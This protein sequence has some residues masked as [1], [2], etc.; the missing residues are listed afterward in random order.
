VEV[1]WSEEV[2]VAGYEEGRC[3]RGRDR[4]TRALVENR[5]QE[6]QAAVRESSKWSTRGG[7]GG[8]GSGKRY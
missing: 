7:G 4:H 1:A 6:E 2:Q 8:G 5:W 3:D